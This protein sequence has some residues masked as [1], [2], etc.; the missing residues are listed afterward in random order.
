M[1]REKLRSDGAAANAVGA[2]LLAGTV[3]AVQSATLDGLVNRLN[4]PGVLGVGGC[5]VAC[6]DS[7][8]Q[9]TE[10]RFDP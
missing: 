4:K 2:R 6:S 8:F 9:P 10:V 3:V 7:S 1:E 5:I